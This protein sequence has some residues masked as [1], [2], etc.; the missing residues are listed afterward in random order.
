MFKIGDIVVVKD[1]GGI[2]GFLSSH[3]GYKT[4][5]LGNRGDGRWDIIDIHGSRN[6]LNEGEFDLA[7]P[8]KQISLTRRT[9]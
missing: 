6:Y 2:G 7:V 5:L 8:R 3:S 1:Y 4:R 9:L